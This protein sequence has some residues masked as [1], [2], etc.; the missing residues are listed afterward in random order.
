[1]I[2]FKPL[3]EKVNNY[4]NLKQ[5]GAF[6]G[7]IVAILLGYKFFGGGQ[8]TIFIFLINICVVIISVVLSLSLLGGL[9][10][11]I[12]ACMS[13]V[14]FAGINILADKKNIESISFE[15]IKSNILKQETTIKFI[16]KLAFYEFKAIVF[17]SVVYIVSGL[18]S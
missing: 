13:M 15:L 12:I 9:V 2:D 7:V 4:I 8:A 17:F 5:V 11:F 3:I 16:K 18:I 1:M 14:Y 10:A 6:L